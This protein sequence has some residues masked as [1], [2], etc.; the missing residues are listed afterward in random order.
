MHD[1]VVEALAEQARALKLGD[2]FDP[3]TTL[4]PVNSARQRERLDRFLS[5]RPDHARIVTGG[6][7]PDLPG[8]YLEPTIVDGLRQDDEMVQQRDVRPGHH[9]AAL[10]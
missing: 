10:R 1:D 3:S 8:F 4:G 9:R 6:N 7:H 2:T 5:R